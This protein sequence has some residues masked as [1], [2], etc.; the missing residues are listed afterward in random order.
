MIHGVRTQD[1][2]INGYGN[3]ESMINE[4]RRMV[5][6]KRDDIDQIKLT[7]F[8]LSCFGNMAYICVESEPT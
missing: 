8:T 2:V 7:P 5:K 1:S 6:S 3:G 4:M